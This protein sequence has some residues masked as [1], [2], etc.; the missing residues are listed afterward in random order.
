M[1]EYFKPGDL[2]RS[3]E[4]GNHHPQ[5]FKEFPDWHNAPESGIFNEAVAR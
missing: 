3:G 5:F 4:V 1:S 2:D